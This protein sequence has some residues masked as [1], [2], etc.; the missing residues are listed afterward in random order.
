MLP[1]PIPLPLSHDR[2]SADAADASS[3]PQE[4]SAM[5]T[6]RPKLPPILVPAHLFFVGVEV[7]V[8]TIQ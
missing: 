6:E 1:A 8:F 5:E 7:L 3:S 4:T 2:Q